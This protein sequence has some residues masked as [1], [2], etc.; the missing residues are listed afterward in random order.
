MRFEPSEL[1]EQEL[2]LQREVREFP[3]CW[4]MAPR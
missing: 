4:W 3:Q 1:S 2:A